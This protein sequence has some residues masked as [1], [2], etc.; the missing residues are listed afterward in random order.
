MRYGSFL[1][2]EKKGASGLPLTRR[3]G[4]DIGKQLRQGHKR[5][6]MKQA[7]AAQNSYTLAELNALMRPT[8]APPEKP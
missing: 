1:P 4:W 7:K 5:K 8:M 6:K 2:Y 3:T